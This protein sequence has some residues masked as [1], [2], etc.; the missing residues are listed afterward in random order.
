MTFFSG[1][2]FANESELFCDRL[3]SGA[4]SAAGFSLG[5]IKAFEFALS[6]QTRVDHLTL[7]S[8]AFFQDK[9][10]K[11]KRLQ[12]IG[13]AKNDEEYMRN[14]YELCGQCDTRFY[15]PNPQRSDLE[16]LL[17]YRWEIEKFN[18][19]KGV[20]ITALI[21]GDDRIVN[22]E[23]AREFFLKCNCEVLFIKNADHLLGY[24]EKK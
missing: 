12:L 18:A 7:L 2:G 6:A 19:L 15:D 8:P 3:P 20:K 11:F 22:A 21:G 9:D 14:F 5:A 23:A 10:E 17:N 1:F 24:K 16:L 13:F 4:F